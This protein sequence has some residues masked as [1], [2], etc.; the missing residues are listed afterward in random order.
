MIGIK[1]TV[2]KWRHLVQEWGCPSPHVTSV[3]H[4]TA[5]IAMIFSCE[6]A[7]ETLNS[8]AAEEEAAVKKKA[9]QFSAINSDFWA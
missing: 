2:Y 3:L 6:P 5:M 8:Q 7:L 1:G 9:L 4:C